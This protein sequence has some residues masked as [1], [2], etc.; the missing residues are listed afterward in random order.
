MKR[1]LGLIAITFAL[2]V[3]TAA[4]VAVSPQQAFACGD[5]QGS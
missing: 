4:V 1:I 2:L 5:H 3:G